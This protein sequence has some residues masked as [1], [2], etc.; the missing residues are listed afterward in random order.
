MKNDK[1]SQSRFLLILTATILAAGCE[2]SGNPEGVSLDMAREVDG[3][4]LSTQC[5][6]ADLSFLFPRGGIVDIAGI[7]G[8]MVYAASLNG[9][10]F[11]YRTNWGWINLSPIEDTKLT[12]LGLLG[13]NRSKRLLAVGGTEE[14]TAFTLDIDLGADD[15][16]ESLH[17]LTFSP[18]GISRQDSYF[19]WYASV[20]GFT[21]N[22][23][24]AGGYIHAPQTGE[25]EYFTLSDAVK[26]ALISGGYL[27]HCSNMERKLNCNDH[28]D[29]PGVPLVDIWGTSRGDFFVVGNR[30]S[31]GEN[32]N[33]VTGEIYRC[34]RDKC[35]LEAQ[36]T[37]AFL[38]AIHG[39]S[40]NEVFVVGGLPATAETPGNSV[41]LSRK[42]QKW[43]QVPTN[44][45]VPL[46]DVWGGENDL[47]V[48]GGHHPDEGPI[49]SVSLHWDGKDFEEI[50]AGDNLPLYAV[51]G[52]SNTD[53]H[54]G[55]EAGLF[56]YPNGKATL[57]SYDRANAMCQDYCAMEARCIPWCPCYDEAASKPCSCADPYSRDNCS[58]YCPDWAEKYVASA[59]CDPGF[60]DWMQCISLASCDQAKSFFEGYPDGLDSADACAAEYFAMDCLDFE[61]LGEYGF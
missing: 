24:L 2:R 23:M 57:T 55:G 33:E 26:T 28:P 22:G 21:K 15:R 12:F 8:S 54:M 16:L 35:L 7:D 44:S 61:P 52:T 58:S 45:D 11:Y 42:N 30:V 59:D 39:K 6:K 29:T 60:T 34:N 13:S 9:G 32:C 41:I 38:T 14:G 51:F 48:V 3:F 46:R 49:T 20:Y 37:G 40:N 10:G 53:V 56:H 1:S 43:T 18:D 47:F 27:T 17:G 5:T 50:S 4:N 31:R 25:L 19:A 36:V